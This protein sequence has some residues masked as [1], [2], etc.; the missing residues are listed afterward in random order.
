LLGPLGEIED[1]AGVP[2]KVSN[3]WVDLGERDLHNYKF[4]N[5]PAPSPSAHA[6]P[7]ELCN[8][9]VLA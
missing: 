8:D 1:F 9:C 2:V 7:Y 4:I 3:G 6:L 5:V